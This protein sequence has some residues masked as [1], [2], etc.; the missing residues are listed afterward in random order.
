VDARGGLGPG[1]PPARVCLV[2]IVEILGHA[3]GS[4]AARIG[5]WQLFGPEETLE[6]QPDC[7]LC[8]GIGFRP[9]GEIHPPQPKGGSTC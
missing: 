5:G 2:L 6:R 4:P 8:L 9:G 7:F 3:F 1:A